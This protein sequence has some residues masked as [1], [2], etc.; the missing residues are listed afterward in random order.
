MIVILYNDLYRY[1]GLNE[2]LY[3]CSSLVVAV[4]IFI[5]HVS[6]LGG[7]LSSGNVFSTLTLVNLLQFTMTKMFPTGVMVRT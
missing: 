1:K 3:F 4:V 7:T 6:I 5:V 2:A